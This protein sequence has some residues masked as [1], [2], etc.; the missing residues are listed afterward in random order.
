VNPGLCEC[1]R[2]IQC[3][4]SIL[5]MHATPAACEGA[6]VSMRDA[7]R[8][9]QRA[10]ATR[11]DRSP[12]QAG[13]GRPPGC[14]FG[15]GTGG[16]RGSGGARGGGRVT[17]FHSRGEPPRQGDGQ[18]DRE[19]QIGSD[20]IDPASRVG[21]LLNWDRSSQTNDYEQRTHRALTPTVSII[22]LPS[23]VWLLFAT[24]AAWAFSRLSRNLCCFCL[25]R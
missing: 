14:P 12:R 17:G 16:T 15:Q 10:H 3:T 22:A 5:S 23:L 11:G 25:M 13:G 21:C 2:C 1:A 8:A 18:M 24:P 9:R 6:R 7:A 4:C 20:G 19:R